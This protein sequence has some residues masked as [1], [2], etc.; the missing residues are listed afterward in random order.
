MERNSLEQCNFN[1]ISESAFANRPMEVD[2]IEM[3]FF[4]LPS[5]SG[6]SHFVNLTRLSLVRQH[7]DR[8]RGLESLSK[9]EHLWICETEVNRIEGLDRLTELTHLYL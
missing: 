7:I 1:G 4:N 3:F 8:I 5:L 2:S 6:L 9:V